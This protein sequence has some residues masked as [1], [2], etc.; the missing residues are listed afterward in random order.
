MLV[1]DDAEDATSIYRL[2]WSGIYSYR[3]ILIAPKQ[4]VLK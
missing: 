4:E 3:N 1:V 2:A